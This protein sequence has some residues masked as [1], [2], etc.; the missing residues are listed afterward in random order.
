[1]IEADIILH[2]RD[3]SHDDKDAQSYDVED[4]LRQLGIE[5]ERGG[6]LIEVWN[7]IDRLEES[8]R[9]NLY[10]L[11]E[12]KAS[13]Q[14]PVLVSALN[15]EG[16]DHLADAI[17][18]RLSHSRV[19][20]DLVLDAADGAGVSWLYRHTEVLEKSLRDDGRIAMTVRADAPNAERA[21]SKFGRNNPGPN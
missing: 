9:S 17:E 3:M 8:D 11:A 18:R 12:R 5:P 20:L 6:H 15:G 4:V 16:L 10:N 2:V 19:V 21:R 14:R 7:K 13:D 1:V